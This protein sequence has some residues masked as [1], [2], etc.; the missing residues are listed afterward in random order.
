MAM[1]E[2]VFSPI[3][4]PSFPPGF[5]P[6]SLLSVIMPEL[7][8]YRRRGRGKG[9]GGREGRDH[10]AGRHW[11]MMKSATAAKIQRSMHPEHLLHAH[12]TYIVLLLTLS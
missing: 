5:L 3:F 9:E 6:V 11:L 4:L 1:E 7:L 8:L 10:F 2:E 12:T